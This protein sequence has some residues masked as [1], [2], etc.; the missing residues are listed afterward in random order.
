MKKI[1]RYYYLFVALQFIAL[2]WV[3][4]QKT[5]LQVVTKTI[6]KEWKWE[7]KKELIINAENATITIE[8]WDKNYLKSKIELIAKHP[9]KEI[10]Q[11][12]LFLQKSIAEENKKAIILGNQLVINKNN[13][14]P[15]SNL[16]AQFTIYAPAACAIRIKNKF[17]SIKISGIQNTVRINSQFTKLDLE[18]VKG[19]IELT[20]NFGD[21][22]G[23]NLAGKVNIN[24]NRSDIQLTHPSGNFTIAAKYGNITILEDKNRQFD[25]DIKGNKA[26]VVFIEPVLIAHNFQLA[27]EFGEIR[28]PNRTDFKFIENSKYRQEAIL[29]Q[30]GN[31]SLISVALSF[32]NITFQ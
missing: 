14:K 26:H 23:Q 12:D 15:E 5:T 2:Q 31:T 30:T 7:F 3:A 21:I 6:E 25:L 1:L 10:A 19:E 13:P 20:T 17:G 4:A 32:G 16:K 29:R 28:V 18:E 24:A 11:R 27:T 22:I 9:I 8:A